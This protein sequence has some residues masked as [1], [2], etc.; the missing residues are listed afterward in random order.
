MCLV[1][2]NFIVVSTGFT[3]NR[4]DN[5]NAPKTE[6][7]VLD[8]DQNE[9]FELKYA[10]QLPIPTTADNAPLAKFYQSVVYEIQ[11]ATRWHQIKQESLSFDVPVF[12]FH[13]PLYSIDNPPFTAFIS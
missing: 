13:C 3:Y 6:L 11:Y 12:F 10:H 5:I 9:C 1:S 8:A 7:P 2:L 4:I